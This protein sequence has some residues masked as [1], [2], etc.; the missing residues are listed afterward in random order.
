MSRVSRASEVL[1]SY[2]WGQTI[3]G[4]DVAS[5]TAD[6]RATQDFSDELDDARMAS[7]TAA[8]TLDD[9]E[10]L[11]ADVPLLGE[12]SAIDVLAQIYPSVRTAVNAIRYLDSLL[13]SIKANADSLSASVTRIAG[14]DAASVSGADMDALFGESLTAARDMQADIRPAN[15][16]IEGVREAA[17]ALKDALE[18]AESTPVIGEDLAGY[19]D[20]VGRLEEQL[21]DAVSSLE[22]SQVSLASLSE[23]LEASISATD[24]DHAAH[25]DRW[26]Q[27]PYHATWTGDN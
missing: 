6:A 14:A 26:V 13:N 2:T 23:R 11:N 8:K 25:L 22:A 16:T 4:L 24:S 7:N 1:R 21:A 3:S 12:V 17:K 10:S 5:M 15:D 19:A 9:I 27:K 20:D 18:Q